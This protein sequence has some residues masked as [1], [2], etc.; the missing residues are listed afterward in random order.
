MLGCGG[1][2]G[3]EVLLLGT[4]TISGPWDVREERDFPH[5]LFVFQEVLPLPST[6]MLPCY[7]GF[8]T[9]GNFASRERRNYIPLQGRRDGFQYN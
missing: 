8:G 6:E 4:V 2:G 1:G 7:R 3:G 5:R 9:E